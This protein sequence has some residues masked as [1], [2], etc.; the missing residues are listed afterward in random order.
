MVR[1]ER[2]EPGREDGKEKIDKKDN[3]K[4]YWWLLLQLLVG[5]LQN[6]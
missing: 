3:R 2:E 5:E 1:V 4:N 6:A